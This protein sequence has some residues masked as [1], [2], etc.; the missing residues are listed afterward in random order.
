MDTS[1]DLNSSSYLGPFTLGYMITRE[2]I[3]GQ[4]IERAIRST[5]DI[6]SSLQNQFRNLLITLYDDVVILFGFS[7]RSQHSPDT[8]CFHFQNAKGMEENQNILFGL[9]LRLEQGLHLLLDTSDAQ[10]QLLNNNDSEQNHTASGYENSWCDRFKHTHCASHEIPQN[11]L[12][13]RDMKQAVG[14]SFLNAF[15]AFCNLC[16]IRTE[17]LLRLQASFRRIPE[18]LVLE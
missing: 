16:L 7:L 10:E 13:Y 8:L 5:F 11:S 3:I 6:V 14:N 15:M 2:I 17:L 4:R 12:G 9:G 1:T 18:M